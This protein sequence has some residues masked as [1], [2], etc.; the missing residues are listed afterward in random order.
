MS[1]MGLQQLTQSIERSFVRAAALMIMIVSLAVVVSHLV[2]TILIGP[3]ESAT[4][5]MRLAALQA[6]SA[7][8]I[9]RLTTMLGDERSPGK[10]Y[11]LRTNLSAELDSFA[12]NHARLADGDPE[13]NIWRRMSRVSRDLF[14][15]P[16]KGLDRWAKDIEAAARRDF[17]SKKLGGAPEAADDIENMVRN[18]FAP[19]LNQLIDQYAQDNWLSLRFV[20]LVRTG[21][22]GLFYLS[23][24]IAATMIF[25]PLGRRTVRRVK[26]LWLDE[27]AENGNFDP[28]T[29]LPN[30]I[31]LIEFI[32]THCDLNWTHGLR[33][34]V[35]RIDIDAPEA[36]L[37]P[38]TGGLSAPIARLIA[39]RVG[40]VVRQGD[41]VAR[42]EPTQFA[43]TAIGL[44]NRAAVEA[45]SRRL[46]T[47][48][49]HDIQSGDDPVS[50]KVRI[51]ASF[52]DKKNRQI[53]EVLHQTN[54]A[55]T[56]N[57]SSGSENIRFYD[58]SG[59]EAR[60]AAALSEELRDGIDARQISP[61]FQ[62]FVSGGEGNLLGI[63][64]V[65][66]WQHPTQGLIG[67]AALMKIATD[68]HL[69][70]E[71]TIAALEAALGALT[72]WDEEDLVVPLISLRVRGADLLGEGTVDAIKEAVT[73]SGVEPSRV[74]F[75]LTEKDLLNDPDGQLAEI[76]QDLALLG[77]TFAIADFGAGR[78][79]RYHTTRFRIAAAMLSRAFVTNIDSDGDQQLLV[80]EKIT[81]S[82]EC[83]FLL[84]ADGVE[85]RAETAMLQRLNCQA[86]AGAL[87]CD[88]VLG[89]DLGLWL[90]Q[91]SRV[92][93]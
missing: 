12:E 1:S 72:E 56:S 91:R 39:R 30:Q 54:R 73:Q 34:A 9:V 78:I 8:E 3:Y 38:E 29:G 92:Y 11:K 43:I 28:A 65:P 59:T 93:A 71:V 42:I 13:G 52:V 27:K 23:L 76:A 16:S 85:N 37:E 26:N 2:V 83:N 63:D 31:A 53:T 48:L 61:T 45:L 36:A 41:F 19:R 50:L 82:Q 17:L 20:H 87:I 46:I 90:D 66:A 62:P 79:N 10:L 70:R 86:I 7:Q 74:R 89:P 5:R 64:V 60:K 55:L 33:Q 51:G 6:A 25:R 81:L 14:F 47:Q 88:P 58:K 32:E 68:T 75:S 44:D 40:S 67:F 15:D 21:F 77:F 69:G 4:N 57:K 49:S 84:V 18:A 24:A 80:A 35:L 22:L